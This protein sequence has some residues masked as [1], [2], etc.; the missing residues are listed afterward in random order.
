[1]WTD[2]WRD[3][4][5][6]LRMLWAS[7]MFTL[8]AVLSLA[9]GIGSTAIVFGVADAYLFRAWPGIAEPDRVVEIGRVDMEGPGPSTAD[10]FTTFSYPNYQDYLQ[11]QTAFQALAAWRSGDAV[12]VG[13][14]TTATR[15]MGAYVTPNYFSVLGTPMTL[16]RA[17]GSE[18]MSL[19]APASVAII[20]HRLW[21]SQF[22][23]DAN[24]VGRTL[25]LNGRP[26]TI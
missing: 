26:F 8:T 5:L 6:A 2:T 13:D 9:I 25:Q 10:G 12:G 1:M 16:G 21:R 7:P 19:T 17:F 14:G 15:V 11:R 22:G 23:R 24:I 3:V 4:R 20:S 18:D